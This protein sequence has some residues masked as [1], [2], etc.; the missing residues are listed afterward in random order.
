MEEQSD[1]GV[2]EEPGWNACVCRLVNVLLALCISCISSM[3]VVI[4]VKSI[5]NIT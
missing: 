2:G 5:V 4:V 3:I 1:E